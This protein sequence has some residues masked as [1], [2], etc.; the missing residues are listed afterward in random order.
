MSLRCSKKESEAEEVES[1]KTGSKKVGTSSRTGTP[2]T[3][4]AR[5]TGTQTTP[6]TTTPR[7]GSTKAKGNG[8]MVVEARKAGEKNKP[9]R[10]IEKGDD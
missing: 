4:G 7:K 6:T 1:K 3:V 10:S 8:S 2:T 9:A 5:T